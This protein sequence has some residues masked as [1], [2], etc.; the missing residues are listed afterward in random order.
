MRDIGDILG[1]AENQ[2]RFGSMDENDTDFDDDFADPTNNVTGNGRLPGPVTDVVL[3][4]FYSIIFVVGLFGNLV[5]ITVILKYHKMRSVANMYILNLAIADLCLL[6]VLPF[7]TTNVFLGY[8]P[9]GGVMCKVVVGASNL[10]GFASFLFLMT[11]SIDRYHAMVHPL[12]SR[13]YR[14]IRR[15]KWACFAVWTGGLLMDLPY[16]IFAN[17]E[18]QQQ[19]LQCILDWPNQYL[20]Q[21]ATVFSFVIGFAIP[22]T[23][24]IVCY[25]AI[26]VCLR[27]SDQ[28]C[29]LIFSDPKTAN[30]VQ[31]VALSF[32]VLAFANSC[33]NPILYSFLGKNFR[34]SFKQLFCCNQ[35]DDV[36]ALSA[37]DTQIMPRDYGEW[38][39][40]G[41]QPK[42]STETVCAVTHVHLNGRDTNRGASQRVLRDSSSFYLDGEQSFY[43]ILKPK[44]S[45]YR[46][47]SWGVL[48]N[49]GSQPNVV[50]TRRRL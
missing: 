10:N 19:K 28:P 41:S 18:E 33:V 5:V 13:K 7:L 30:I 48:L 23:V 31:N 29:L 45:G 8:W 47:S 26:L 37:R 35:H 3:P 15:C 21:L 9:F 49:M 38:L 40:S 42:Q 25:W 24:I 39:K 6:C 34:Q 2:S 16:I 50:G 1:V 12:K 43:L 22:V 4:V 44:M 36:N 46:P 27:R 11:L 14:T 32:N 17:T 20:D